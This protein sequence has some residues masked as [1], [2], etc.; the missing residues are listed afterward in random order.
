MQALAEKTQQSQMNVMDSPFSPSDSISYL[1]NKLE[2]ADN[3]R[4][5]EIEN[6]LV[7]IGS[8][9]VPELVNQL[10]VVRGTIR[11]VVAMTLIRIGEPSIASLEEAAS[12][13]KDFEWVAQYLIKEIV[14]SEATVA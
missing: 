12:S 3:K 4:K 7:N 14:G 11:G 2:Q 8:A 6:M 5:N 1:L 9:A 13:N 10:Q